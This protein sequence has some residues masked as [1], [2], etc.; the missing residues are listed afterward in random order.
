M[1]FGV[2][3]LVIVLGE[4]VGE[5]FDESVVAHDQHVDSGACRSVVLLHLPQQLLREE[6]FI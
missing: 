1:I 5:L 6:E 2:V 4:V 3:E